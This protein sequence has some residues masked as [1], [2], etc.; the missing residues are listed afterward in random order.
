MDIY[1]GVMTP[2]DI[3]SPCDS[4]E[5][6]LALADT[7][8]AIWL[9][10]GSLIE[11]GDVTIV[12]L[13]DSFNRVVNVQGRKMNSAVLRRSEVNCHG[14]ALPLPDEAPLLIIDIDRSTIDWLPKGVGGPV[15]HH[16]IED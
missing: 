10:S 16:E 1:Y 14:N 8:D 7:E 6:A 5:E 9:C 3:L 4:M 2:A 11:D 12:K 15:V 13:P